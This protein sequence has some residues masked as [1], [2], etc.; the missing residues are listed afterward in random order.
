[1]IWRV[2]VLGMSAVLAVL[3]LGTVKWAAGP[4][5]EGEWLLAIL[6]SGRVKAALGLTDDQ[7]R[8]LRQIRVKT[9]KAAIKTKADPAVRRIELR[10]LLKGDNPV[11]DT[12]VK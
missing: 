2:A 3:A 7:A 1:M 6:D 10:E 11:R 5:H 4:G 8:R 12:V 9:Q